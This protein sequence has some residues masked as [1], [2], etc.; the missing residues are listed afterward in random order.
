MRQVYALLSLVERWGAER[1]NAACETALAHEAVNVALIR[2]MLE[3][4]TEHVTL[5]PSL[6]GMVITTRFARDAQHFAVARV[7]EVAQ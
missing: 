2:R 3:Q 1:V 4:G 7:D 5:Q 6:P